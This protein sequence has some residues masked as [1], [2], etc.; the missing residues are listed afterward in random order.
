MLVARV[1]GLFGGKLAPESFVLSQAYLYGR[2]ND[3]PAHRVEVIDGD[4]IDLRT[5]LDPGAIGKRQGRAGTP[6]RRLTDRA[7][8]GRTDAEIMA[9][10]ELSRKKGEWHNAMLR[11]TAS[12][13]GRGWTDDRIYQ[14]CAPYCW[15]GE[16]TIRRRG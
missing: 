4:F 10:L 6:A 11:A 2:V 13:V 16:R 5:D 3:N 9:L 1:N 8:P 14:T 7:A 15:G 12:M